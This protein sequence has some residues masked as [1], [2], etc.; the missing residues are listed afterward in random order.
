MSD[1][2]PKPLS[3]ER[4]A[5][6]GQHIAKRREHSSMTQGD[7]MLVTLLADAAFWR[8]AVRSEDF[9]WR[10]EDG[11]IACY[12]CRQ[13]YSYGNDRIIHKPD[14]PWLRAQQ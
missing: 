12:R 6:I 14:C 8:E 1:I 4:R 11:D 9:E 5:E 3:A 13:L 7:D 10:N 2:T